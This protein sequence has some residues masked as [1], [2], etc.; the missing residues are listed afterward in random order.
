MFGCFGRTN[1][2]GPK[3]KKTMLS[4][5]SLFARAIPLRV[6]RANRMQSKIPRSQDAPLDEQSV[7]C[8]R[9]IVYTTGVG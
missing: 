9:S 1:Q 4:R 7:Y 6:P 2:P 5:G 8:A 3:R